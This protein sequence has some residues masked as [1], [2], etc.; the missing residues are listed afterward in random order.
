LI[1]AH[2]RAP[3]PVLAPFAYINIIFMVLLGYL[4]FADIPDQ[5]TMTG[6]AIIIASGIYLLFRE[7]QKL[8]GAGPASA[9]V[10]EG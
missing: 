3:A 2:A 6:A 10:V 1:L 8:G 9:T 5:W 7:R 4:V